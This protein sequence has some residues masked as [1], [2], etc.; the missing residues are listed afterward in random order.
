MQELLRKVQE[1]AIK[2]TGG[3]KFRTQGF[4]SALRLPAIQGK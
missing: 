4:H 1:P 2:D 3:G